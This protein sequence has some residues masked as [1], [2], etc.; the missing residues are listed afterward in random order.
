MSQSQDR[1]LP[2]V[3]HLPN[4]V[5]KAIRHFHREELR[6]QNDRNYAVCIQI[7]ELGGKPFSF[8]Q[9]HPGP[10]ETTNQ[11]MQDS[12]IDDPWVPPKK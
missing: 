2:A 7:E 6:Y 4:K 5:Q 12:V 11:Q 8:A 3:Q 10:S 1:I 9:R